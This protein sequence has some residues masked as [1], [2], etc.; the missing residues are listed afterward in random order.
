MNIRLLQYIISATG[1]ILAIIHLLFPSISIDAVTLGL[2]I[3]AVIPWL[4]PIFKSVELPGGWKIEF[5]E[6]QKTREKAI[7]VGLLAPVETENDEIK[8]T[9]QLIRKS[10]PNLALAALRLEIETRLRNIA[11]NNRINIENQNANSIVQ[12]FINEKI[13]KKKEG[14]VILELLQLLN[15]VVHGAGVEP[16]TAE[17]VNEIGP[18]ILHTLDTW[19]INK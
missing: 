15:A 9:F 18:R 17:W 19:Q 5:Q 8:Y 2:I 10:D 11:E 1:V 3:L 16:I 12:T 4:T 14:Q 13:F 7:N 6:F